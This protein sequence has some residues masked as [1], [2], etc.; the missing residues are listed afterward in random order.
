VTVPLP[1]A[2]SALPGEIVSVPVCRATPSVADLGEALCPAPAAVDP[3]IA[4]AARRTTQALTMR[5]SVRRRAAFP[6]AAA[7]RGPPHDGL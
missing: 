6:L 1:F 5:P 4:E 3:R 7:R 2:L